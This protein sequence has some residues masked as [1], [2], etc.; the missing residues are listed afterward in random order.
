MPTLKK[1]KEVN[2]Q[3]HG[4]SCYDLYFHL[5]VCDWRHSIDLPSACILYTHT[6]S[7]VLLDTSMGNVLADCSAESLSLYTHCPIDSLDVM[8]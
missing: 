5:G 8:R 7:I 3:Q 4:H 6:C 1:L 2:L